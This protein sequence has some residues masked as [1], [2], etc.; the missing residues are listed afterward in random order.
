LKLLGVSLPA[1]ASGPG[2]EADDLPLNIK[3][4]IEQAYR[5]CYWANHRYLGVA[6][7]LDDE[8][9]HR[10]QGHSWGDVHSVL[11]HM[12]SSETVWFRR[13]HGE[14]PSGHLD[15]QDFPSIAALRDRWAQVE[16]DMRSFIAGQTE[17]G[18]VAELAYANFR[19]ERFRVP[20]W[21]ML[22]HVVNHETHH[23][24]ELAAMFALMDVPHPEDE[25][26]QYFLDLSGQ[27]KF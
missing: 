16:S 13:W 26:I 12:M 11:V 21:Q 18:L 4:Y 23:R 22:M 9:L 19:G 25:V 6:E 8:R 17:A 5:Y 24:G 7:A 1:E 3:E 27:K 14:S 20:L 10:S 15:P 2:S